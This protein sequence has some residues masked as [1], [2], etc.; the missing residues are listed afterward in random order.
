MRCSCVHRIHVW[1]VGT[2]RWLAPTGF[3]PQASSGSGW[4]AWAL[5]TLHWIIISLAPPS[6][7][8]PPACSLPSIFTPLHCVSLRVLALPLHWLP[9]KKE[10]IVII[11]NTDSAYSGNQIRICNEMQITNGYYCPGYW[12]DNKGSTLTCNFNNP[13]PSFCHQLCTHPPTQVQMEYT[14]KDEDT[15][16]VMWRWETRE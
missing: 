5:V 2:H 14:E 9:Q 1:E 6:F 16:T 7:F 11:Q 12:L 8:L 13:A 15:E 10:K 4:Q 3:R